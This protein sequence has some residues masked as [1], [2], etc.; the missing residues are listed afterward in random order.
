[1]PE[2]IVVS[3]NPKPGRHFSSAKHV[4]HLL[5]AEHLADIQ[6]ERTA[7]IYRL[8]GECEADEIQKICTELLADPV[9]ETYAVSELPDSAERIFADVW[10]KKGVTDSVG[11]SVVRASRELGVESL[12]KAYAGTRYLFRI[13]TVQPKQV[14][15]FVSQNLLNPLVQEC[16]IIQRGANS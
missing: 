12:N 7:N 2:S 10:Y 11:E 8:E 4:N 3:V 6:C 13:R 5:N 14:A 15:E 1:M 9:A 16:E